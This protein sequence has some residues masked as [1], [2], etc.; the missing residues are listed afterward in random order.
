MGVAH[1][2]DFHYTHPHTHTNVHSMII[3]IWS[4]GHRNG[5]HSEHK[6]GDQL[7][8]HSNAQINNNSDTVG[9][10]VFLLV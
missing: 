2:P 5:G 6:G 3:T 4:Q 7:H 10:I 9:A 1:C 8:V